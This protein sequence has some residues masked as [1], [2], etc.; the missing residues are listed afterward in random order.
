MSHSDCEQPSVLSRSIYFSFV[1]TLLVIVNGGGGVAFN[2]VVF[3]V[4]VVGVAVAV[5]GGGDGGGGVGV[6]MFC[7]LPRH[8]RLGFP[9]FF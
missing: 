8:C 4:G 7:C 6:V 1:S 2:F 5:A 3:V 9:H